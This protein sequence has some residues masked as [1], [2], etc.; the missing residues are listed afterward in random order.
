MEHNGTNLMQRLSWGRKQTNALQPAWRELSA[1]AD[2]LTFCLT[3]LWEW[4]LKDLIANIMP[5]RSLWW[6][7]FGSLGEWV[8]HTGLSGRHGNKKHTWANVN[9]CPTGML[10]FPSLHNVCVCVC[11]LTI[12][13]LQVSTGMSSGLIPA[14]HLSIVGVFFLPALYVHDKS[15]SPTLS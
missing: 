1:L 15:R 4:P 6:S 13:R 12:R 7:K 8:W 14:M 9:L 5:H 10:L 11:V 2:G 3:E